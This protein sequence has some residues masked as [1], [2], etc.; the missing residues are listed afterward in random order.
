MQM[1]F[2][3]MNHN[4]Y[5]HIIFYLH[6]KDTIYLYILILLGDVSNKCPHSQLN[7]NFSPD[8]LCTFLGNFLFLSDQNIDFSCDK[9]D[10]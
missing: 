4:F 1:I 3:N 7:I 5:Q 2:Y 8:D 10:L 9:N 6:N